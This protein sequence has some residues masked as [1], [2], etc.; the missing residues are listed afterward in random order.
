MKILFKRRQSTAKRGE[1]GDA[2]GFAMN[3]LIRRAWPPRPRRR[4]W[5]S[6]KEAQKKVEVKAKT[7]DRSKIMAGRQGTE[8]ESKPKPMK[9]KYTLL[10]APRSKAELKRLGADVGK[11]K[12]SSPNISRPPESTRPVD[13]GDGI[14]F[15]NCHSQDMI[16]LLFIILKS[17][18]IASFDSIMLKIVITGGPC[19]GKSSIISM[20]KEEFDEVITVPEAATLLLSGGFPMPGKHIGGATSAVCPKRLHLQKSL[21]TLIRSWPSAAEALDLRQR[22]ALGASHPAVKEED[23]V[24]VDPPVLC[25]CHP[26]GDDRR[27]TPEN[28]AAQFSRYTTLEQA[29]D[30]DQGFGK[31][32]PEDSSCP[33]L[34][35]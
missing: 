35:V 11:R 20:L 9:R 26:F 21:K 16:D 25:R 12:L 2:E 32:M 19:A 24:G 28:T 29:G 31:I 27:V 17:G 14:R 6:S 7:A 30:S 5:P 23:A 34:G 4:I 10:S 8:V 3:F 22:L 13:F 33:A 1:T 15:N 18:L